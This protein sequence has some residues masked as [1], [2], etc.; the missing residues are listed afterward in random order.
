MICVVESPEL[1]K[2]QI[3]LSLREGSPQS[4]Q[5]EISLHHSL[6]G[7]S[8][9]EWKKKT[10]VTHTVHVF[11]CYMSGAACIFTEEKPQGIMYLISYFQEP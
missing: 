1:Q 3:Q 11:L 10:L 2:W 6:H 4:A 5:G 8:P 7:S 9:V